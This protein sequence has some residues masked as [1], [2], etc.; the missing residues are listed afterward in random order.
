MLQEEQAA[1]R[2]PDPEGLEPAHRAPGGADRPHLE[3]LEGLESAHRAPGGAGRSAHETMEP[4]GASCR[5]PY[6]RSLADRPLEG[7]P[8]PPARKAEDVDRLMTVW[9]YRYFNVQPHRPEATIELNSLHQVRF[10][11]HGRSS[12]W[13]GHWSNGDGFMIVC[14]HYLGEEASSRRVLDLWSPAGT[15]IL[16]SKQNGPYPV[17]MVPV[18]ARLLPLPLVA[19][20]AAPGPPPMPMPP[21]TAHAAAPPPPPISMPMPSLTDA[22][23]MTRPPISMP[24][25]S[26]TDA[27]TMT[28]RPRRHGRNKCTACSSSCNSDVTT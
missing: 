3:G 14:F 27:T 28:R 16:I 22:T 15:H 21:L 13:H 2:R 4:L 6:C 20:A 1:P 26:L 10:S 11:S 18:C 7:T 9:S 23:T 25:P 17:V 24:T 12:D 19:H 8:A 5:C